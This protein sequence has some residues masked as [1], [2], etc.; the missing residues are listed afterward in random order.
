MSCEGPREPPGPTETLAVPGGCVCTCGGWQAYHPFPPSTRAQ[1]GWRGV[2]VECPERRSS[3]CSLRATLTPLYT[4][5]QVQAKRAIA[6]Q[7][8]AER[9]LF[10]EVSN[11]E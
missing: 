4:H 3:P 5:Q 2:E 1:R 6:S 9:G 7:Q 8:F 10:L 11:R